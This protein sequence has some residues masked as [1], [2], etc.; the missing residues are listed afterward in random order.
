MTVIDDLDLN[1]RW[2]LW[3]NTPEG[4]FLTVRPDILPAERSIERIKERLISHRVMNFDPMRIAQAIERN[5][6]EPEWVGAP[7]VRFN[8]EKIRHL[9]LQVSPYQVRMAVRSTLL[10][11]DLKIT[12]ADIEFLLMEKGV[13][14]GIDWETIEYLLDSEVYDQETIIASADMPVNGTDGEICEMIAIDPDARPILLEDGSV[15][16]RN[17]ENIRKVNT[18]DVICVRIPPTEG[19]PGTSVFNKPLEP[20]PGRDIRLP[21]GQNTVVSSDQTQMTAAHSGYLF[22]RDGLIH[23]G[24]IYIVRGDVCFKSGN[25]DYN[26]DVL[27]QGCVLSD[28][29]VVADGDITIEGSVDGAEIISR[30]GS[31]VV[32]DAV[33]GKGKAVIRAA[34]H[35]TVSVAQDCEIHAGKELRV[36]RYLRGSTVYATS[37]EASRKDCEVSSCRVFFSQNVRCFQIG[38]RSASPTELILVENEREKYMAQAQSLE[39]AVAKLR[40][41]QQSLENGLKVARVQLKSQ[42]QGGSPE[43]SNRVQLLS[44]QLQAVQNK[45]DWADDKRKRTLRFLDVLPDRDNLVECQEMEPVLRVSIY[46][47]EKEYRNPVSRWRMGWKSG[48]IRMESV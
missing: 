2:L 39:D 16:Y 32:R 40:L 33:F 23:V 17:L 30:Q 41:A 38:G 43:L 5:T 7:F 4:V 28:F 21:G 42:G 25:V 18:G 36:R 34:N 1:D 31:V 9:F 48:A 12:R 8:D 13:L 29:R 47:Q 10:D 27:I 19:I 11:T 37:V 46:G 44:S 24:N 22:R 26:G 3:S 20:V 6:G 14:Y 35:V 45:L 15:D